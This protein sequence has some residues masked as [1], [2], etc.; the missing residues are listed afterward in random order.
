M[1]TL[2][3]SLAQTAVFI[4]SILILGCA[5]NGAGPSLPANEAGIRQKL[6][7]SWYKPQAYVRGEERPPAGDQI[8]YRTDGTCTYHITSGPYNAN[9]QSSSRAESWPGH[10]RLEGTK[11][12]RTWA[13]NWNFF[14]GHGPGNGEIVKLTSEEMILRIDASGTI[15]HY[16]RRPHWDE[17]E[18]IMLDTERRE[19]WY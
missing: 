9:L 6:I 15:E 16:Y 3:K 5:S 4:V 17:R 7:G 10:W 12:Y 14:A 19:P 13:P 1:K 2:T 18:P 8:E 11:L